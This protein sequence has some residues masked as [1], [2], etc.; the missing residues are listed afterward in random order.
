GVF[1]VQQRTGVGLTN[2][3]R[4]AGATAGYAQLGFHLHELTTNA[5]FDGDDEP[6]A[7]PVSVGART[8]LSWVNRHVDASGTGAG[9]FWN[10]ARPDGGIDRNLWSYNQGV[11]IGARVLQYRLTH[12]PES[13]AL[14]EA[15]ARQTLQTFGDFTGQ[16]PSF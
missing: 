16:P 9:P 4:G 3:D 10:V 13:L 11:M 8:M 2:H 6:A 12:E 5:A 7:R 15:I 14:A 1:W